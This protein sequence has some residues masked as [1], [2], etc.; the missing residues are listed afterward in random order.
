MKKNKLFLLVFLTLMGV[1]AYGQV[2]TSGLSGR[3]VD[4]NGETLPG[5]TVA[6]VHVPSGTLYG[7]A[8]NV[9]G[10]F[11]LQGMRPGGPYTVEVSFIGYSKEIFSEISL[12]LGE[13]FNL[14]VVMKKGD[15]DLGEVLIVGKK[16]SAFKTDKAGATTN[17]SNQQLTQMPTISRSISDV[18]RLSPFANGMSFAGGDGRSTNFTVDGANFNNNFG[19]SAN[20]PGG[21]NPISLDAIEEVQVVVSPFDVRQTNFIG[22]GINAIT[23]SGTNTVNATLYSYYTNQD[24]RGNHIGEIDFGERD[25]ESTQTYGLTLGGPIIK[26]KLFFFVNGEYEHQPEQIVRWRASEGGVADIDRLL[27]RASISDMEAVRKHLIDNYNYDPGSFT[28]F[29]ADKGNR[30]LLARLDWNINTKNKLS[31]RYNYTK[32]QNWFPTNGNSTD[33]GYRNRDMNRIS[34]HSMAFANSLYSMDNIVSSFALDLNSRFSEKVS[35]QLL[36]TYTSIDDVR[37]STSEPFPF[38]D[39]MRGVIDDTIQIIEPYISAG[40]ELFTWNNGVHNNILNIT[41]NVNIYL[42]D[43]KITLGANFEYQM[44]NNAYMRNGTGYYRYASLDDFLNQAA[45]R[46]F[47]LTYGYAGEANPAAEVAFNQFGL[48]AQDEWSV[49]RDFKLTAGIRADYIKYADNLMRN[50]AIYEIDFG[51]RN[52]DTGKWPDAKLQISPRVGF[53][54]DMLGN[55]TMKLRGGTGLFSGRLPLVFFT[56]MPTNSGMVQGSYRAVTTYNSDGTIDFADPALAGLAGPML[57]NIDDMITK[58]DLPNEI[59]PEQGVLPRDINGVDPNFKMPQVWKTSLAY[60]VEMPT[61]FPLSVTVEGI[62]TKVLNDVMLKNYALMQP[63]ESWERFAGPDDRYIYP[64]LDDITYVYGEEDKK[65]PNAYV[66]SNTNEGWGAIGNISVFAEPVD[67]LNLMLAYTYTESKEISGMPGSNAGS[68][69][70]GLIQVDGPH[71]PVLQRSQYVMPSKVIGSMGYAIPYAQNH[72]ATSVNLFYSGFTPYGNSFTYSNDMNGDGIGADLIYIPEK[73]GDV[74]FISPADEDAFF[75]FMDQDKYLTKNKGGYAEANAARAPWVHRFDL[76]VAQDF[77]F[78]VSGR[79]NTV[80]VTLDFINFGNLLN[81]DWGVYKSNAISNNGA[82]LK[83]EGLDTDGQTPTFS[84]VKD[85]DGEFLN[86]SYS[87]LFNITQVWRLQLGVR[88]I[89]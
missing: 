75:K 57:T 70:S 24:F 71:L 34:Q 37:G 42:A 88:Y 80:Q 38:I 52:I 68:A 73:K 69:Y 39:I 79:K 72:M 41:D 76:R 11:N 82:I 53:T 86:Q 20:L 81:S 4:Q 78:F 46:D 27:S 9:D 51:G 83:Y 43:H 15:I 63:D 44:A 59:T 25:A 22:G 60:E 18:A 66:L 2:T 54:W 47:A 17:I 32:N 56:N 29:P 89:F 62:F 49:S 3:V 8:T 36:A 33:A 19:L 16:S 40:Y 84:M 13:T 26:N 55:Q 48:Y 67:N 14:E 7:A 58:L 31:F 23:K 10:R 77:N 87:P 65:S 50:N 35:N 28:N 1:Y 21:G 64:D 85:A 30:K 6:A 45:P 12:F 74:K 5:A 61:P